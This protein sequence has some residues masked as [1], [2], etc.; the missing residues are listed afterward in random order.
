MREMALLLFNDG[1][2][3]EFDLDRPMDGLFFH[4]QNRNQA[5][6][7][8]QRFFKRTWESEGCRSIYRESRSPEISVA[9]QTPIRPAAIKPS[10]L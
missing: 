3:F 9:S 8:S 5:E 10:G 4:D 7:F 6:G 2:R 1:R